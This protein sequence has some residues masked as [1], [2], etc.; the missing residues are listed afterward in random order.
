ME[1]FLV[2]GRSIVPFIGLVEFGDK[3][4]LPGGEEFGIIVGKAG[5][6]G[7]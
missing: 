6:N 2:D 3:N 7:F 4:K 1:C 5:S